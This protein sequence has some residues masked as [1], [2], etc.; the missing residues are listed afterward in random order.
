MPSGL[1]LRRALTAARRFRHRL[2][3][4]LDDAID[5]AFAGLP[6]LPP[7]KPD[8]RLSPV[9]CEPGAN[10]SPSPPGSRSPSLA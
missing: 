4:P 1:P 8:A 9:L 6:S 3:G 5:L 7:Y 2:A 10:L